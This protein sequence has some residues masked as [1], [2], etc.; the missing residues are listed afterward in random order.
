M[1][2]TTVIHEKLAKS[3]TRKYLIPPA[4]PGRVIEKIAITIARQ[5]RIGII[6]L[7]T[8]SIPR[9]TPAKTT[10]REQRANTTNHNSADTGFVMNDVKKPS[11]ATAV[12]LKRRYSKRYFTTQPP[13]TE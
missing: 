8:A 4:A 13:I 7:E 12:R 9:R 6:T 5:T 11:A 3:G 2:A 10:P 1:A